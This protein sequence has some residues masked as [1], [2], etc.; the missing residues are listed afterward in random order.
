MS[1][2]I[3]SHIEPARACDDSAK[4]EGDHAALTNK[5][6]VNIISENGFTG[7]SITPTAETKSE[8]IMRTLPSSPQNETRIRGHVDTSA[9]FESVKEA[10]LLLLL[11]NVV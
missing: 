5:D 2:E 8:E 3:L 6:G 9:P 4:D 7:V 1:L 11:N 10:V